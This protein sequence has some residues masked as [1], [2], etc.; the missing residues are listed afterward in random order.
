MSA[1][2]A[3]ANAAIAACLA[4][5]IYDEERRL[6]Y[7]Q[8]DDDTIDYY[9]GTGT[10]MGLSELLMGALLIVVPAAAV[11]AAVWWFT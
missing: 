11:I 9:S 8:G 6:R 5:T 4:V 1:S 7:A 2:T 3:G 10:S